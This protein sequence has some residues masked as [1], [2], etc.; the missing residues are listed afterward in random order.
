MLLKCIKLE[1]AMSGVYVCATRNPM[2]QFKRIIKFYLCDVIKLFDGKKFSTSKNEI[3]IEKMFVSPQHNHFYVRLKVLRK[4]SMEIKKNSILL[5]QLVALALCTHSR[6]IYVI[7]FF[8]FSSTQRLHICSRCDLMNKAACFTI[9]KLQYGCSQMSF[10]DY[11][12]TKN[13]SKIKCDTFIWDISITSDI[14]H[15]YLFMLL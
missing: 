7:F 4:I 11:L 5:I 9:K 6:N 3:E 15:E 14:E 2:V 13:S 10:I 12:L 1:L 8:L